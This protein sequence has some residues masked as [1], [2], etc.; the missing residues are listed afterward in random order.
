MAFPRWFTIVFAILL[1]ASEI[2]RWRGD[3]RLLPMAIDEVAVAAALLAGAWLLPRRGAAPLAAAWAGYSGLM[4]ALLV[5]TL[6]H[7]VNGPPKESADFYAI[8][9]SAM[10]ALGLAMT[11]WALA[12][13]RRHGP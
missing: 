8:L 7:L 4:L 9:L 11:G 6:D 2:A 1:A 3:P 10:L 12:L 5:P 13:A